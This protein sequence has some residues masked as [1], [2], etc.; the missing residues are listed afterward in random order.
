MTEE[1]NIKKIDRVYKK[2]T[3]N[4]FPNPQSCTRLSQT[5]I[6]IFEL[7]EIIKHFEKKFN[8]VPTSAQLLFYN[9]NNK[10]E[11]LLFE[12]YKEEFS[13]E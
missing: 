9:Y 13:I 3:K 2:L 7:N 4:K 6:C 10:Q 5:R 1:G 11:R 12:K 8:Y